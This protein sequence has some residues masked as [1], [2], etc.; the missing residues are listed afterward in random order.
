M[1][2]SAGGQ[3]DLG[4]LFNAQR[5]LESDKATE[6]KVRRWRREIWAIVDGTAVRSG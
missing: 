3:H 2:T 4:E 5:G 1:E 6:R